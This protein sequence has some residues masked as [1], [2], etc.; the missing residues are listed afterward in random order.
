M[1]HTKG[2]WVYDK[3]QE[4][5]TGADGSRVLTLGDC[6]PNGG[7]PNEWDAMLIEA[8][9]DLL[10]VLEE[11]I[12]LLDKMRSTK[13]TIHSDYFGQSIHENEQKMRAA[14]AKAKG[15]KP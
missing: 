12:A 8:A 13:M 6:Y 9:P 11:R 2:P 5:L 7:D 14:I 4:T 10:E 1:S 3:N 15:L